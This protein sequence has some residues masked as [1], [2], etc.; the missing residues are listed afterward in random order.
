MKPIE[1]NE[2]TN[3]KKAIYLDEYYIEYGLF[4][5]TPIIVS[6]RGIGQ[7]SS[8]TIPDC[9][10]DEKL[11]HVELKGVCLDNTKYDKVK[12]IVFWNKQI[13]F[14]KTRKKQFP[15]L[16]ELDFMMFHGTTAEMEYIIG[17]ILTNNQNLIMS[18][19]KVY[20]PLSIKNGYTLDFKKIL[21][22]FV[23]AKSVPETKNSGTHA[24]TSKATKNK[25]P[26]VEKKVAV[27]SKESKP[28][29][30]TYE[31]V[32]K[33]LE[34]DT[35]KIARPKNYDELRQFLLYISEDYISQ[36]KSGKN[37]DDLLMR[38]AK[39]KNGMLGNIDP[40]DGYHSY[41]KETR[42]RYPD[43]LPPVDIIEMCSGGSFEPVY[44][45]FLRLSALNSENYTIRRVYGCYGVTQMAFFNDGKEDWIV[46]VSYY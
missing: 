10:F 15:N 45:R 43:K 19:P 8:I 14:F 11:H 2:I 35:S 28:N 22:K 7:Q 30:I 18:L 13:N 24:S 17:E 41:V 32:I 9:V 29:K 27:V 37:F 39:S 3:I 5:K 31:D 16:K 23:V 33:V 4:K 38:I 20:L 44:F 34:F 6:S 36:F 25:T 40:T 21:S 46:T 1:F 12:T 42:K 26:V